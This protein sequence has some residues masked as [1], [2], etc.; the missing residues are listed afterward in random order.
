LSQ[1]LRTSRGAEERQA[2]GAAPEAGL[3][4]RLL[5]YPT[6]VD[7]LVGIIVLAK[8]GAESLNSP[9]VD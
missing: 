3:Q 6:R 2:F 8:Q 9:R 1:A 7:H 5:E 4:R